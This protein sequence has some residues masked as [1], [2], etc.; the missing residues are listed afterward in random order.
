[1]GISA[2][3]LIKSTQNIIISLFIII[4]FFFVNVEHNKKNKTTTETNTHS[5]LL[6]ILN[7]VAEARAESISWK[8]RS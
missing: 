8:A 5:R 1:M 3:P 6:F 2:K 7:I 4:Y